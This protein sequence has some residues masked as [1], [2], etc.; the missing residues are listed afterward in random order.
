MFGVST[1]S[2][3]HSTGNS[4]FS[5]DGET[6]GENSQKYY[7]IYMLHIRPVR[8]E[9]AS[10]PVHQVYEDIKKTLGIEI[11][12]LVFQ[13]LAGFE[14]YFLYVWDKIKQN[15]QSEFLQVSAKDIIDFAT[16]T[17]GQIYNPSHH[18]NQFLHSLHSSEKE[19][20]LTTVRKLE[21]V[22]A[23]LLL[24]TL[25]MREGL[26]GVNIGAHLLKQ[27]IQEEGVYEDEIFD[28][29]INNKIMRQNLKEHQELE[30][31]SK[32]LAPLFGA[33]SVMISRYPEFFSRIAEE[34]DQL[35]KTEVYLSTRVGLER[36][37]MLT[38]HNLSYPLGTSYQE[39][40]QFAGR[41]PYFDEL[42]YILSETFPTQFPR[43]VLTTGLMQHVLQPSQ[44]RAIVQ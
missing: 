15:L 28:Q 25:G 7:T 17:V 14:E 20:L 39:I 36:I 31:A 24:V 6:G 35:T 42:L 22:N 27:T 3:A 43:L 2:H 11:V 30:G 38:V 9:Q 37:A 29:F 44:T 32:M 13:Y 26:K 5:P 41:R 40:A 8:E 10:Q 33:S 21:N 1:A 19:H 23:Q 12:P 4:K 16:S 18:M 34:M